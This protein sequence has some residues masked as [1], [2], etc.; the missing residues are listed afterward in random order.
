MLREYKLLKDA[1]AIRR[2]DTS[3]FPPNDL[4]GGESGG[5]T[6][7]VTHGGTRDERESLP[8]RDAM[9]A[10]QRCIL[11]TAG[12]GG[13]GPPCERAAEDVARDIGEGYVSAGPTG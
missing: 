3:K 12:G 6:R 10:G 4:A 1:T 11:Q 9:K 8:R 7:L 5:R 2:L 13:Y